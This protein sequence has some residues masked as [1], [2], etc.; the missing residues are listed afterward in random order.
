MLKVF[1]ANDTLFSSNGDIVINPKKAKVHKE[2]N[3]EFYL[4]LETDLSYIDYLVANNIIVAPTPQ[5]EQAF[6]ILNNIEKTKSKIKI[7]ANHIFYDSKNYLIADSYVDTK[8]C[9]YALDHLN[10]ATDTKSPFTTI[11]D[12]NSIGSYR[13]VRTNLCDAIFKIIDRWGGHLV[14]NNWDIQIRK[15]IG[16]DN[17]VIVQYKKNLKSITCN[18]NWNNVVTKLLP[19][20]KDGILLDELYVKSKIQ[21]EIPYTKSISF[22]QDIKEENYISK[23]K[24]EKAL[25]D[26]LLRQ[27][28]EYLEVHQYPEVNYTLKANLEKITDIGDIVKVYDERL[29]IDILTNVISYDYD[30]ISS[31]YTEIEFGNFKQKLNNLINSINNSAEQKV[32]EE[33]NKVLSTLEKE[34]EKSKDIMWKAMGSSYVIY[35]GDKILIVDKLPKEEAENVILIN[36]TGIAFSKNG[37]NGDFIT[38]WTIDGTFNAQ[39]INVINFTADLIKGGTLKLGSNTNEYGTLEIY[40]KDNVLIGSLDKDG[41]KITNTVNATYNFTYLDVYL[42]LAHI[43]GELTLPP[44]LQNLYK[45]NGD[46]LTTADV[47]KMMN[48]INGTDNTKKT[49]DASVEINANSPDKV[50]NIKLSNDLQTIVGLFQIY[51]YL[52]KATQIHI[53]DGYSASTDNSLYGIKLNGQ[54]KEIKITDTNQKVVTTIDSG[55]V[56][57]YNVFAS[58]GGV[59]GYSLHGR[60]E[61]HTY[62]IDFTNYYGTTYFLLYVDGNNAFPLINSVHVDSQQISQLRHCTSYLEYTVPRYGNFGINDVFQS[63]TKLKDNIKDTEIYASDIIKKIKHI[64]FDWKKNKMAI[65]KGHEEIGYSANQIESEIGMNI[66][67]DVEQPAG[68]EFKSIKQINSNR[69]TPLITKTLQEVLERL[70][71]IEKT[72]NIK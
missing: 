62:M 63:D 53:G 25:K 16:Q 10:N 58:S 26:D 59:K 27:A 14:R 56:D 40:D 72:L 61:A 23:V 12:V 38:A 13:C 22:N 57:A 8:N 52:I 3:G 49:T 15:D 35:D 46:K 66:V 69:L 37:I 21:Y 36:N 68:S 5:G 19:V 42:L 70:D 28:K 2:D 67:Y 20:G 4:D 39:N 30:C 51:S 24:Y 55:K 54:K 31:K 47:R 50:I 34:L 9:N 48:I 7:K 45:F 32:Q 44:T 41:L 43:T 17:D 60:G 64:E 6:R 1:S 11:S 65:N 33:S 71:N 18:E 29:G